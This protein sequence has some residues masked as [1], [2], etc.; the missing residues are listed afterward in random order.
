MRA[1]RISPVY[2]RS[3]NIAQTHPSQ[4]RGY[5]FDRNNEYG[6]AHMTPSSVFPVVPYD[7]NRPLIPVN[8][9]HIIDVVG[10][11][12]FGVDVG[13]F[14]T[15]MNSLNGVRQGAFYGRQ[16]NISDVNMAAAAA[17]ELPVQCGVAAVST[18]IKKE[19]RDVS[20]DVSGK[21]PTRTKA[22]YTFEL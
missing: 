18:D 6:G 21:F 17:M 14:S 5:R 7:D 22:K 8:G 20:Y 1:C 4:S 3:C 9:G 10:R 13:A 11:S 12:D 16:T 15:S 19:P 2:P